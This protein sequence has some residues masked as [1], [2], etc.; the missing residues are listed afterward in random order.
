MH[1]IKDIRKN[2]ETFKKKISERNSTVD[3]D[4]LIKLDEENRFLIQKKEKKEQEKKILS[5]SK[6]ASNFELS[7]KLIHDFKNPRKDKKRTVKIIND[8]GKKILD[9]SINEINKIYT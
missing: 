3:F 9:K 5:K 6:D 1:N 4:A 2:L 8:L 7:K